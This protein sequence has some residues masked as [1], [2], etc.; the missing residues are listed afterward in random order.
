MQELF[1]K[2]EDYEAMLNQGIGL[3]GNDRHFFIRGRLQRVLA[4]LPAAPERILDF[5]C[6]TGDTA[7]ELARRFPGAEV[8]GSDVAEPALDYARKKFP[9][10]NLTFLPEE[11][12]EGEAFDLIYLNGVVHHIDPEQRDGITSRLYA[13][14]RPGGR[15]WIFENNP[16]NPGTRWA[17]YANPFDKGV[18]MESPGRLRKRL[19]QAGF[20]VRTC[21]F[22]FFFPRWLGL[23]RF[24]EPALRKIPLGGQYGILSQK[25][26]AS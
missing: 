14:C 9:L 13:L 21:E 10:P 3:T 4:H 12:L 2:P 23:F 24:L 26:P 19:S 5:G 16:A 7:A 15:V 1:D 8:W 22:L 20:A 25:P 17:M 18:V 11:K 6:G